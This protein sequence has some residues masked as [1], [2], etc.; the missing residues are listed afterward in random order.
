[1]NDPVVSARCRLHGVGRCEV[2]CDILHQWRT[3]KRRASRR[4]RQRAKQALRRSV[5]A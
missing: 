5:D 1:M 4:R 2:S 3:D